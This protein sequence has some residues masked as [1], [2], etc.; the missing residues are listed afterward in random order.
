MTPLTPDQL[1][2]LTEMVQM[3]VDLS[4]LT[5]MALGVFIGVHVPR[6]AW[7]IELKYR[8]YKRRQRREAA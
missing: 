7:W 6:L 3:V 5:G 2:E 1:A 4:L 8:L